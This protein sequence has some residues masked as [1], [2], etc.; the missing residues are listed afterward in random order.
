MVLKKNILV[1]LVSFFIES[2]ETL[3]RTI[4]VQSPCYTAR[5]YSGDFA[6]SPCP[7]VDPPLVSGLH[8][9]CV[10]IEVRALSLEMLTVNESAGL[11]RI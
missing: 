8:P 3:R 5:P 4:M 1:N 9:L 11:Q 2:R 6:A 10:E 7:P